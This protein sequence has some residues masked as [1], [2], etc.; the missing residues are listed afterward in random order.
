MI[1][2]NIHRNETNCNH[3]EAPCFE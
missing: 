3:Q 2:T 1:N